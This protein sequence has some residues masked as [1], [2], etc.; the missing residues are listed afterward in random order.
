MLLLSL[1][2]PALS[3]EHAEHYRLF[4]LGA[5]AEG[6]VA[7]EVSQMRRSDGGED[8]PR[9]LATPRLVRVT[10]GGTHTLREYAPMSLPMDGSRRPAGLTYTEGLTTIL[11]QAREGAGQLPGFQALTPT[12]HVQCGYQ[13]GCGDQPVLTAHGIPLADETR[14]KGVGDGYTR[15]SVAGLP[16]GDHRTYTLGEQTYR[17]V[18]VGTGTHLPDG[19][20]DSATRADLPEA[21]HA[22]IPHHGAVF[23]VL[24]GGLPELP[25][26]RHTEMIAGVVRGVHW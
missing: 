13:G 16:V 11:A 12:A 23:D 5:D 8:W 7:L 21:F 9:W 15:A 18:T 19:G 10:A 1:V 25:V 6:V 26:E 24:I 14:W 3:C 22:A 4:P 2:L 20:G 17:V